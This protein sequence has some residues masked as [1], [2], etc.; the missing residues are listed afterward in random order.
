MTHARSAVLFFSL[1]ALTLLAQPLLAATADSAVQAARE[2]A[3]SDRH[4]E[5]IKAFE[6]AMATAP[7]RR[8]EWLIEYA[9]QHTWSGRL[10]EAI[11]LYR[12]AAQ[13]A[14]RHEERRARVGLARA[15]SWDGRHASAV[16]EYQRALE[17]DPKD[18]DALRGMARVQSWR[19]RHRDAAA[20]MHDYLASHPRDREAAHI[21]AESL[22]WMG[23]RDR[24]EQVLREQVAADRDD[25]RAASLL[26]RLQYERRPEIRADWRNFNQSDGLDI[27]ELT[28][29]SRFYFGDGRGHIGPRYSRALYRPARGPASQIEVQR[30]GLESRYRISDALDWH[31]NVALDLIDTQGAAGDHQRLT[32]DTYLT[33]WP[34]DVLRFDVGASRW[35]FDSEETLRAGFTATQMNASMDVLPDDRTLLA[36]RA[37]RAEYSD[38]NRRHWWQLQAEYRVWENPRITLGYRHT[39][40][41][42]LTPGQAGYFNPDRYRSNEALIKATGWINPLVHWDVRFASGRESAQPGDTR[43]IRSGG[44]S[45]AWKIQSALYLELAYDWS[46]SRTISTGGF[47]RGIGRVTL[48]HRF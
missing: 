9:D 42:F 20:R 19:G 14:D 25:K 7:E 32:Y 10:A 38:G 45:I 28:L 29:S 27:T 22:T 15:L 12:E 4:H 47:E 40:F 18:G 8:R 13:T 26:E 34:S 33:F 30:P 41:G 24:A 3:R 2:A 35:T 36:A 43:P 11:A 31:G 44:A 5:A 46:T 21:L 17:L 39:Q 23:R 6:Q 1:L 48:R 37:S 16:A